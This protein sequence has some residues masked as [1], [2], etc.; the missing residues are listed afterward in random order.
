MI[1]IV[2]PETEA[3]NDEKEE[4]YTIPE[5]RLSFEHSLVS[6]S[7]WEQKYEKPFLSSN[8]KTRQEWLDYIICMELDG[9]DAIDWVPFLS[10]QNISDITAYVSKK[11]TATTIKERSGARSRA[12][13]IMTSEVIYAQMVLLGIPF[14]CQHWHLNRL[15]T[16]IRVCQEDMSPPKKMSQSEIL[17]QNRAL[18]HARLQKYQ[19]RG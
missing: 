16:L 19:T 11:M 1:T 14:E 15:L 5:K 18:N 17:E 9:L 2:T 13:R 7:K 10:S 3:F 8:E 12:P 4:F 6:L